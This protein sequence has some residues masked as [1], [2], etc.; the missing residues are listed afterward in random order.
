MS[1][2]M[3]DCIL[4]FRR[5]S[6]SLCSMI[7]LRKSSKAFSRGLAV[8]TAGPV[9]VVTIVD[10]N[11]LKLSKNQNEMKIDYYCETSRTKKKS[12]G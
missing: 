5:A 9:A 2:Y 10:C 11:V 7:F 8:E 12:I 4:C 1:G 6:I 3:N